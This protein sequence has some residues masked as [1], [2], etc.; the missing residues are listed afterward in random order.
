MDGRHHLFAW[1]NR[2]NADRLAIQHAGFVD[3]DFKRPPAPPERMGRDV[4]HVGHG[5]RRHARRNQHAVGRCSG[6][7]H[8]H[9][10]T[11]FVQY[12]DQHRTTNRN[13]TVTMFSLQPLKPTD[14]QFAKIN[15]MAENNPSMLPITWGYFSNGDISLTIR[16][17][18]EPNAR[19]FQTI[20]TN[21]ETTGTG[22]GPWYD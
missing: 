2:Q 15:S 5:R 14:A 12:V 18:D 22:S 3:L 17:K 11:P 19:Y 8:S 6:N 4:S 21:G 13:Q 7:G 16:W 1:P 9:R 20:D 10:E